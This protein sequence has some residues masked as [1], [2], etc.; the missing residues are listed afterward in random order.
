VVNSTVMSS[1]LRAETKVGM[2]DAVTPTWLGS[3]CGASCLRLF[4]VPDHGVGIEGRAVMEVTPDAALNVHFFFRNQSTF[5]RSQAG[6][7]T[8]P[9]RGG[10][11]PHRQRAY[12]GEAGE[13]V[14]LKALTAAQRA[15]MSAAVM[16]M[17]KVF[18]GP[19]SAGSATTAATS[20]ITRNCAASS[21]SFRY[22]S[23]PV[24]LDFDD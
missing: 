22:A 1:I 16:P 11:I 6:N 17:R 3:N 13:A 4:D 18:S 5:L 8:S 20:S 10:Q 15:R 19:R 7:T 2:R 9:V 12:M 21:R 14:T 23:D 24:L